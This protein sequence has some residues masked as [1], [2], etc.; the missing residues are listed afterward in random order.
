M[1]YLTAQTR[2]YAQTAQNFNNK[3]AFCTVYLCSMN[4]FKF[5][6]VQDYNF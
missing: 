3:A 2:A 6:V 5:K 4:V 1:K